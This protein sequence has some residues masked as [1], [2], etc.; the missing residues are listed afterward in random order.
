MFVPDSYY[1][2]LS[3]EKKARIGDILYLVVGSFGKPV[4]IDFDKR[5]SAIRR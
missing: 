5:F 3:E 2:S 4:F 1:D